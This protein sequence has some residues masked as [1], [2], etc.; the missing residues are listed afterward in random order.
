MVKPNN[1]NMKGDITMIN[2]NEVVVGVTLTK[3]LSVSPDNEAKK[4][5]IKK[6]FTVKMKYDGLTLKDIFAKALKD[7]II[8]MQNGNGPGS[9]KNFDKIVDRQTIEV[10]AKSPG[11]EAHI[12]PETA[13]IMKLQA[14]KP[15][16]QVAYLKELASKVAKG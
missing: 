15:E 11:A 7:D 12:D 1:S 2:M 5:G 14:M 13:M 10:S 9:R 8:S 16:E 4:E 3:I 6:T